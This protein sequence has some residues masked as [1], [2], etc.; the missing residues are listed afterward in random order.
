MP[1]RPSAADDLGLHQG[2]GILVSD[3]LWW[4]RGAP[5]SAATGVVNSK[6]CRQADGDESR[7]EGLSVLRRAYFE[8]G[9]QV[10]ALR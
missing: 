1:R 10:Q 5:Y 7:N 6:A 8:Q 3:D 9:D 2:L 4:Q